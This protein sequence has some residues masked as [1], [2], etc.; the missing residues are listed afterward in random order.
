MFKEY[1]K[2]PKCWKTCDAD[3]AIKRNLKRCLNYEDWVTNEHIGKCD[4]DGP[5]EYIKEYIQVRRD[6]EPGGLDDIGFS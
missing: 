5:L 2:C 4:Y 6:Y 3:F 1:Y